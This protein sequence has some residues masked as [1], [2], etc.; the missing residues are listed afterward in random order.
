MKERTRARVMPTPISKRR[1]MDAL[2]SL[3]VKKMPLK[4][5]GAHQRVHDSARSS[6][7]AAACSAAAASS[8]SPSKARR[9]A[10]KAAAERELIF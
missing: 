5:A 10:A 8:T 3:A 1:A 4:H 6:G 2:P 9:T 7:A